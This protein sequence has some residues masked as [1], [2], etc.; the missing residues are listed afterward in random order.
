MSDPIV[1]LD[2]ELIASK[3]AKH[4][5]PHTVTSLGE[6]TLRYQDRWGGGA[7]RQFEMAYGLRKW[8]QYKFR[9]DNLKASPVGYKTALEDIASQA[10]AM[11]LRDQ[12]A[13]FYTAQTGC[14]LTEV[15]KALDYLIIVDGTDIT[16][17][18][19]LYESEGPDLTYIV[20]DDRLVHS[21]NMGNRYDT[22]PFRGGILAAQS[23]SYSSLNLL[24][25][26]RLL[27]A[28]PHQNADEGKDYIAKALLQIGKRLS[29]AG[30]RVAIASSDNRFNDAAGDEDW[31]A[32]NVDGVSWD[33]GAYFQHTVDKLNGLPLAI[34]AAVGVLALSQK[35]GLREMLHDYLGE[36]V[37]YGNDV[38]ILSVD[39]RGMHV[40]FAPSNGSG[41]PVYLLDSNGLPQIA[42]R[43]MDNLDCR[44]EWGSNGGEPVV[45]YTP[46]DEFF[47]TL[48]GKRGSTNLAY[49]DWSQ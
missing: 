34:D 2:V 36:Q 1:P 15:K 47:A 16:I 38:L 22:N 32:V 14:D 37:S 46:H 23:S 12:L 26:T 43:A 9:L 33:N 11:E 30:T 35:I 18:L 7:S 17:A 21:P 27:F 48:E 49:F 41:G 40:C 39:E 42:G 5:M 20:I 28:T 24:E 10:H 25:Q 29:H 6:V 13:V 44:M 45:I 3:L 19:R 4:I 31:M 8:T